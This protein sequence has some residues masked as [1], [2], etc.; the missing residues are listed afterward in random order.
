MKTQKKCK[1]YWENTDFNHNF[2]FWSSKNI[3]N[4]MICCWLWF[5]AAWKKEKNSRAE[6]HPAGCL[7]WTGNLSV[8][9]S[10]FLFH[11]FEGSAAQC[12]RELFWILIAAVLLVVDELTWEDAAVPVWGSSPSLSDL[13]QQRCTLW[14]EGDYVLGWSWLSFMLL[15]SWFVSAVAEAVP[16]LHSSSAS[17]PHGWCKT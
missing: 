1:T 10:A 3:A 5:G 9:V 17:R 7:S 14:R 16:R 8:K 13:E 4:T 12:M 11:L 2:R 6:N 15:L